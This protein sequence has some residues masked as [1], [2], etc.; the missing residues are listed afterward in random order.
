MAGIVEHAPVY[1]ISGAGAGPSNSTASLNSTSLPDILRRSGSNNKRKKRRRADAKFGHVDDQIA[2]IELIQDFEFPEASNRVRSSRDGLHIVATGTYKPQIRVWECEQL[3]LKFERHTDAENVDF[4]LLSDDWT[5]S[6]HLQSDRTLEIHSQGGTHARIRIPKFGRALG[7]HFPSADA[8]V[9]AAGRDVF[10]LNLDQGR[11]LAPFELGGG[12]AEAHGTL[13]GVNALDINPAHGLASFGTEGAGV[14][15]LWDMRIRKRAGLLS[16]M[17]STIL[18]SALMSSRRALPGVTDLPSKAGGGSADEAAIRNAVASLSVTALASADDG[19]NLAVG[20]ST[21]HTLL[22]DLRM[23]RPYQSKDQGF[24]LPIKSLIWPGSNL[25]GLRKRSAA[26]A[27]AS[28][29][30]APSDVRNMVLS[31]DAKIIKVWN[32]ETGENAATI[33]PPS[34]GLDLNDVHHI[35]GT[36]LVLGAVEGTQ[37]AAWYVPLLGPAPKW[38]SFLDNLTTEMDAGGAGAGSKLGG[39]MGGSG[40]GVYE[41]FKFVDQAELERLNMAHLV[42]TA[43]LRPYMHGYFVSLS[44]YEKARL[45]ANPTAYADARERALR[46]RLEKDAESRIR[47]GGRAELALKALD[48]KKAAAAAAG[49]VAL[50]TIKVNRDLAKKLAEKAEKETKR[51]ERMAGGSAAS[52]AMAAASDAGGKEPSLLADNRFA[53]LFT[54]PDYQVDVES[55]EF[56]MLNPSTAAKMDRDREQGG[57]GDGHDSSDGEKDDGDGDDDSD[58]FED[59]EDDAVAA[60]SDD[61]SG[62]SDSSEETQDRDPRRMPVST[63]AGAKRAEKAQARPETSG[64]GGARRSTDNNSGPSSSGPGADRRRRPSQPKGKG[65]PGGKKYG[66]ITIS[67]GAGAEEGVGAGALDEEA[68]SGRTRRRVVGRS[69]SRNVMR[70]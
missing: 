48:R 40:K 47:S 17:T 67:K 28:S 56:A 46:A 69:A 5:K 45:L 18:D 57:R 14:V 58:G 10:R 20:T 35:P 29:S 51:K 65:S 55:R 9:G 61:E 26:A 54:N 16:I 38:C 31:A 62:D 3:A 30:D 13:T 19:L 12:H 53:E 15:E 68:R 22:Y 27:A 41:D 21:G 34:S 50:D 59:V 24:G 42:G 4:L 44:L 37:M 7:Y 11:F 33:T 32:S 25:S 60:D 39:A 52:A 43:L 70:K 36:G 64:S 6:L 66:G 49:E 8:V 2:R 23:N 63:A 1:T